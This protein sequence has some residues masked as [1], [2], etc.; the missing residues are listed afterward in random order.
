MGP[1]S[2]EFC[3][4]TLNVLAQN[5]QVIPPSLSLAEA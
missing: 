3:H 5:P 4:Q 1:K 2:E